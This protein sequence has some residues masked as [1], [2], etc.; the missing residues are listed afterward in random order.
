MSE[1]NEKP[2]KFS[3]SKI[4]CF[5]GC[6]YKY[7]LLYVD[8][9]F[10]KSEAIATDFGTLIHFIEETMAK[11]I[12]NNEKLDSKEILDLLYNVND[13]KEKTYGVNILKQKYPVQWFEKDKTEKT[14]EDKINE[15]VNNGMFRLYD[16]LMK[17]PN[18]E[19]VGIEQEFNLNFNGYIFH[20]FID[21]VFRDK[22]TG[23]IY[24][25]DIKTW[26]Q[27]KDDK[28]PLQFVFYTLAAEELYNTT[29]DNISCAYELPLCDLK[30]E[31]GT[32]GFISRGIKKINKLLE[33]IKTGDFE[34]N[35]SPLCHW[36]VFSGTFPDQPEKAKKL[37]PYYSHWTKL[38]KD[39]SVENEWLGA[40]NHEKIMEAFKNDYKPK[41]I[42]LKPTIEIV[43]SARRFIIRR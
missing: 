43:D 39:F 4:E 20:G 18:L 26:T 32:K 42:M 1:K 22:N 17:N 27:Q 12:K 6:R 23:H 30:Y 7:K 29:E 2:D 3:Y 14:Y 36:C 8:K 35:P 40:E 33:D 13:T 25:E 5:E 37:C 34:P 16:H 15:Y 38:N 11:K 28:T 31:A 19:I 21:R 9:H 24:I 10:I 41:E